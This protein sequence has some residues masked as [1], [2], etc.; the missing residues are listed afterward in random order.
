VFAVKWYNLSPGYV[1]GWYCAVI[2]S[3]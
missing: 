2:V 1:G 3:G